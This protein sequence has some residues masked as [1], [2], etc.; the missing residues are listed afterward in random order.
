MDFTH[1]DEKGNA[2][3]VDVSSKD[4]TQRTAIAYGEIC[5]GQEI[6]EKIEFNF[7]KY[8]LTNTNF[9]ISNCCSLCC[10]F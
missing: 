2:I 6:L 4:T 7:F 8:F 9:T 5:V 3:M 1:F 10:V